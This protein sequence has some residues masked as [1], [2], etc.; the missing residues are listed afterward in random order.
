MKF[1]RMEVFRSKGEGNYFTVIVDGEF[2]SMLTV[3][4]A[5]GVMAS[6]LFGERPIFVKSYEAWVAWEKSLT[7]IGTYKEPVALLTGSKGGES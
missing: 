5:L 4:E 2:A 3:D 1:E 6:A 7:K